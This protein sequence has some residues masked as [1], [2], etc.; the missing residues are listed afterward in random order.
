MKVFYRN[1]GL[2]KGTYEVSYVPLSTQLKDKLKDRGLKNSET[3]MFIDFIY[4][5]LNY[6]PIKRPTVKQCLQH[7]L[8]ENLV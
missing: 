8:F 7:K 4:S 3:D 6:D 5:T 1:N 2:L